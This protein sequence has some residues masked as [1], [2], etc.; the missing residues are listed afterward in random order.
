MSVL[1]AVVIH[2]RGQGLAA[3][4]QNHNDIGNDNMVGR[5]AANPIVHRRFN[6]TSDRRTLAQSTIVCRA[7][8][9]RIDRASGSPFAVRLDRSDLEMPLGDHVRL[10]TLKR[11]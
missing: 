10:D 8:L 1:W 9:C 6:R 2:Q 5:Q 7:D 4:L 11:P 3:Q